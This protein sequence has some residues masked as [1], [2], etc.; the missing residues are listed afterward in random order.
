MTF[1]VDV[2]VIFNE[3]IVVVVLAPPLPAYAT[4]NTAAAMKIFFSSKCTFLASYYMIN[5]E[6]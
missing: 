3:Y 2:I 4:H 5:I 1:K 6:L